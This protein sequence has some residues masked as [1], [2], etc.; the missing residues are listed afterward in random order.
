MEFTE[1]EMAS[2]NTKMI[3]KLRIKEV[4][5]KHNGNIFNPSNWQRFLR[6]VKTQYFQDSKE[7]AKNVN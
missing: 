2:K 6:V 1:V 4:K 5:L 3:N 7:I